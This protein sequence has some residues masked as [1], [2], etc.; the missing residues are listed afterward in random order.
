LQSE[1]LNTQRRNFSK[2]LDRRL[3]YAKVNFVSGG[4][5]EPTK[6]SDP[7]E[8]LASMSLEENQESTIQRGDT[9]VKERVG[10]SLDH[11]PTT[12]QESRVLP[13]VTDVEDGGDAYANLLPLSV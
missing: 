9:Q 2:F 12:L 13:F 10:E 1:A 3:R 6:L 11:A 4:E 5:L 7:E 8:A